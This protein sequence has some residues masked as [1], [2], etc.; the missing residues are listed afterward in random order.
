MS[1][2]SSCQNASAIKFNLHSWKYAEFG[3]FLYWLQWSHHNLEFQLY[4]I[5]KTQNL[6]LNLICEL[7][8]ETNQN[9]G[10]KNNSSYEAGI[11]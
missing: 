9:R 2:E 7:V 8:T 6:K 11:I 1:W 5:I 3:Q 4:S 10:N